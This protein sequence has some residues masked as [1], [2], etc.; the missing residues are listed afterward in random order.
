[1]LA[2]SEAVV[3]DIVA[4]LPPLLQSLEALGFIARHLN[5]PDFD[6]VMEAAGQP[7]QAL[8]AVRPRLADWPEEFAE[9]K[10]ALETASDA[11]LAAFEGLRKVQLGDGDLIAVFRALRYAPRAQ[12]ALYPLAAKLPPVNSFFVDPA[13]RDDTGLLTRLAAPANENTG[14]IH[15]HNEAGSRGGFSLYIPE[16]YTPDRAWP[17][18][19]ALHGGSGNGRGFLWSW[20]RDA[21]SLG[22]IVVAPTATG[23]T[24]NKSTWALMGEDTDTPNLA[25]ILAS[26]RSRW[27]IDR[28]K[29]LLTGMSDGGTFCYVTG[30]EGASP[31]THLAP[32]AATFHPLMA[33]MADAERL[34]GL[35]IYLV[36]GRLD[37]MFPVQVARQTKDALAAAGA[38]VTYRELDDLS[39][40]YPREM[41][42]P[43]LN[44]LAGKR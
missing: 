23:N 26:V 30:L 27:N 18:V 40:C 6:R 16:Y 17:L 37:W 14:I 15:D 29:L 35:P 44:W 12:E 11:A 9:I 28:T 39:H 24:S 3:D 42:A 10:T 1:M 34:R 41:N 8:K 36:H 13:F 33:E 38:D 5:P 7:D 19:M 4:V 43:I 31:F 21:R 32:V 2:M 20:L 25:R 22:A